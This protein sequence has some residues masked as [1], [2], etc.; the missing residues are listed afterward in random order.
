MVFL[1]PVVVR[2]AASTDA[3]SLEKYDL[4]RDLQLQG[5]PDLNRLVPLNDPVPALPPPLR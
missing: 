1:R 2:D 5:Q 3:L 4:I